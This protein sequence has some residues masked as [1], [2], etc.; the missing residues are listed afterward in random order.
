[1]LGMKIC[2]NVPGQMT[3]MFPGPYM[4]KNLKNI[5][6]FGTKMPMNLKL[7]IQHRVLKYFHVCSVDGPGSTLAIFMTVK[8]V[9]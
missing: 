1:M 2:S 9:S 4:G 6:F 7:G 3:K 5:L 8:S